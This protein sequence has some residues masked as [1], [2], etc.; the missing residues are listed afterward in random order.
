V[1][2]VKMKIKVA[3]LTAITVKTPAPI[4]LPLVMVAM[5]HLRAT[6]SSYL[7]RGE[8]N[9]LAPLVLASGMSIA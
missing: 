9:A 7:D 4:V 2:Q 3:A 8:P 5:T 6:F 1:I